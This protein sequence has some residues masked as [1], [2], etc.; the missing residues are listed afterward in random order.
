VGNFTIA[1]TTCVAN[2]HAG[3]ETTDSGFATDVWYLVRPN[4]CAPTGSFDTG[5]SGQEALR[6]G[7]IAASGNDC[8]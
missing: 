1:T 6:D 3:L 4:F 7:S 5:E 8:P 2:D